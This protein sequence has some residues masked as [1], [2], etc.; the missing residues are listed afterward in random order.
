MKRCIIL[1]A[2]GLAVARPSTAQDYPKPT[3]AGDTALDSL[4]RRC[5]AAGGLQSQRGLLGLGPIRLR[6]GDQEKLR[7]AIVADRATLNPAVT[8]ALIAR[9]QVVSGDHQ[10]ALVT[11]LRVAG[12][13]ADDG[14]AGAFATLFEALRGRDADGGIALLEDAARRF[15]SCEERTWQ[16]AC[17]NE[18]GAVL[19]G[20][21]A[22][23]RALEAHHKALEIRRA[24]LGERHPQVADSYN[25]IAVVYHAQGEHARALEAHLKALEIGR[26]GLGER[27]PDV[28]ASYYNIALVYRDQGEHAR[29]LEAH[30]RALEIRRAALGERHPHVADSYNGIAVVYLA[31][32]EHAR[33]L[34]AHL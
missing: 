1:P 26:A 2:L 9:W 7:A 21:A 28:A 23:A 6:I 20:R 24:A 30:L 11:L 25:G 18:I 3:P 16:A 31:L 15:L 19:G 29:A 10:E 13:V 22:F 12:D 8:D 14:R 32:G 5:V 34:E 33:A 17:Y 4:I 27:H